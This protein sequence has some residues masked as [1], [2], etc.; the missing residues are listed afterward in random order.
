MFVGRKKGMEEKGSKKYMRRVE[1]RGGRREEGRGKKVY[2]VGRSDEGREGKE[3]KKETKNRKRELR[4][5][6]E[7]REEWGGKEQT[8]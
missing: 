6:S 8:R 3:K 4:L 1:E 5:V 7:K 2:D